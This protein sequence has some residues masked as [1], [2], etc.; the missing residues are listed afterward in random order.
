MIFAK[1]MP[2]MINVI[3]CRPSFTDTGDR[4]QRMKARKHPLHRHTLVKPL[5]GNSQHC[6]VLT[7]KSDR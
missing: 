3:G 6:Q 2:E 5:Q 4:K 1:Y 7:E